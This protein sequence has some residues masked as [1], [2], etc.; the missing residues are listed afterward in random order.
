MKVLL[1]AC[2]PRPLRNFLP[3]HIVHTAQEMGWGQ[4]KN[5]ALLKEAESQFEALIT[6]DQNLKYQQPAT[7][8][9]LAVLVLPTNDWAVLRTKTD[10]IAGAVS[11]LK[12]G[13]FIELRWLT[14]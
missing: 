5:G 14:P 11:M 1:D 10:E 6:T 8:R 9:M 2:T 12:A 4:L 13:D 7:S 3:D